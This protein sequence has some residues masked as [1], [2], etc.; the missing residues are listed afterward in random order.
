MENDLVERQENTEVIEEVENEP[1][2]DEIVSNEEESDE[3]E[4]VVT[5]GEESPPQ[6]EDDTSL[7]KHLRNVAKEQ[8]KKLKEVES[9][10][11]QFETVKQV[12]TLKLEDKPTIES[13]DYDETLFENKILEWHQKKA[14]I[15]NQM[16]EQKQYQ[17]M[18][19]QEWQNTLDNYNEKKS[20]LRV[21]DY[22][23]VED[24]VKDGLDPTQQG[25]LLDACKDPA[26]FVYAIG[27]NKTVLDNLSKIKNPVKFA[28]EVAR[29]ESK[30]LKVT[31]KSRKPTSQPE[32]GLKGNGSKSGVSDSK[33]ER[34]REE[35]EKT[36][37]YA[38]LM[39]YKKSIK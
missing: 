6:E 10:L 36:G 12:E 20:A 5:L 34:L 16:Q 2:E 24:I 7:V 31:T 25:V 33:L 37:N 30:D 8:S 21:P 4:I 28:A 13:C 22:E 39:A 35:A 15:D 27:K 38:K 3:D 19:Q 23:I 32:K 11:K 18:Q 14:K 26:L 29:L 17:E 1:T 9:K